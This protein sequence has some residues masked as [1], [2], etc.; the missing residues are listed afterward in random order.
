M[1]DLTVFEVM[2][3][4]RATRRALAKANGRGKIAGSNKPRGRVV[5]NGEEDKA[6][7]K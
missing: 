1:K 5:D 6:A 7:G 4:N 3:F 2:G